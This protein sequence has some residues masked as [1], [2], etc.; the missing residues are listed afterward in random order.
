MQVYFLGTPQSSA[1]WWG[2]KGSWLC[3]MW[4]FEDLGLFHPVTPLSTKTKLSTG[5]VA[6]NPGKREALGMVQEGSGS[7]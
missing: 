3:S 4:C 6:N 5:P 7:E 2:N 1:G